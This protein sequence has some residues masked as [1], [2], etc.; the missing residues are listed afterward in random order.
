MAHSIPVAFA[1]DQTVTI[2]TAQIAGSHTTAVAAGHAADTVISAASGFLVNALVTA[3]GTNAMAIYD[4]ATTHSGTIVG[5]IP[6][7]AAAGSVYQFQMPVASGIT[8]YGN[9]NNP[10][11]TIGY[12]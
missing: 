3:A 4:N 1:S 12:A 7:N 5:Y 6:A 8:V 2:T 11:V 9:A 10:A